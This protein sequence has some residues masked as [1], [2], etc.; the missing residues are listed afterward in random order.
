LPSQAHTLQNK[1]TC[2]TSVCA[3]QKQPPPGTLAFNPPAN[4]GEFNSYPAPCFLDNS[5]QS[6]LIFKHEDGCRVHCLSPFSGKILDAKRYLPMLTP[7]R[8]HVKEP[9]SME[10]HAQIVIASQFTIILTHCIAESIFL[11]QQMGNNKPGMLL[12]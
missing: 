10:H 11:P 2:T 8:R 12:V 3:L 6:V 7:G 1:N 4:E 9:V 5:Q